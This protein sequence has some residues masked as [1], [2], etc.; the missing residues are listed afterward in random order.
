[1]SAP[2]ELDQGS[3]VCRKWHHPTRQALRKEGISDLSLRPGNPRFKGRTREHESL[4]F[5]TVRLETREEIHERTY[6]A[7]CVCFARRLRE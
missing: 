4:C 3:G 2:R 7:E 5:W 6:C 1:M